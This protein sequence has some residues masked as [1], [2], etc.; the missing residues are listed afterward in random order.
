MPYCVIDEDYTEIKIN[1]RQKLYKIVKDTQTMHILQH[2]GYKYFNGHI[3]MQANN[4][5]DTRRKF[6]NV[7]MVNLIY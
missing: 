4:I 5:F 7:L 2:I 3:L 6:G 1:N